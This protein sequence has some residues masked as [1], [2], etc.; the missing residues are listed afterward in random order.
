MSQNMMPSA[1][2][3]F[4]EFASGS[5][6]AEF[7]AGPLKSS[8]LEPVDLLVREAIQNSAD[9]PA[10][11][12][13]EGVRVQFEQRTLK[14][15]DKLRFVESLGLRDIAE[16]ASCFDDQN[17]WYSEGNELLRNIGDAESPLPILIY[18]DHR[19][20]GL[21]GRW[22]KARSHEDRF[23]RL[24]LAQS[25]SNKQSVQGE[26]RLGSY[27]IGKNAFSLC[28]PL[29]TV[30]YFSKFRDA[31][32]GP[33]LRSRLM[34]TAFLPQHVVGDD[35]FTGHAYWG[36]QSA[37]KNFPRKPLEDDKAEEAIQMLG[38]IGRDPSDTGTTVLLPGCAFDIDEIRNSI[39]KWWW[40]RLLTEDAGARI[41]VVLIKDG[42]RKRGPE[43]IQRA[44]L[45][46]YIDCY[47]VL[48]SPQAGEAHRLREL[49]S[50]KIEGAPSRKQGSLVL[51][52]TNS[53]EG[54]VA[55]V[56]S[57]MVIKYETN[58]LHNGKPP[59]VGIFRPAKETE[60]AFIFAEPEAHNEI[61]ENNYRLTT[62]LSWGRRFIVSLK[63]NLRDQVRDFQNELEAKPQGKRASD[64]LAF[65]DTGLSAL[66]TKKKSGPGGD[67]EKVKRAFSI[68]RINQERS[69][70]HDGHYDSITYQIGLSENAEGKAAI[71]ELKLRLRVLNSPD[72]SASEDLPIK[73]AVRH[74]SAEEVSPNHFR[75]RIK[76]NEFIELNSSG[77]IEPS[78]RTSWELAIDGRAD[79]QDG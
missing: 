23:H 77:R 75:F 9:E 5:S 72:G 34:V 43:P 56:R 49:N 36:E 11:E 33:D 60:E 51:T 76:P 29:R 41:E 32:G 71:A 53:D 15:K 21:T 12:S 27:G 61:S 2:W 28:S 24:V 25:R 74:T 48:T 63:A 3:F 65:L 17:G 6:P 1:S 62:R 26:S 39:E 54:G 22:D 67:V 52:K 8:G 42:V 19:T 78:W 47:K 58:Y 50:P 69:S 45:E 35:D 44:D 14:G 30:G 10:G 46:Q 55:L 66:F 20:N 73:T 40:P 57:G 18:S 59:V 7:D 68:R 4:S 37:N 31:G 38:L 70:E 64:S 79:D 13:S 16:R